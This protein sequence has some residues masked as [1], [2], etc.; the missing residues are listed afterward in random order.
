M[1]FPGAEEIRSWKVDVAVLA[2]LSAKS[3]VR[4]DNTDMILANFRHSCPVCSIF[5]DPEEAE[6]RSVA[7]AAKAVE[8]V[9][10]GSCFANPQIRR[11]QLPKTVKMDMVI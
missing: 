1:V 10:I 7:Q 2:G 6:K 3:D 4:T 5:D 8:P 9:F 11:S